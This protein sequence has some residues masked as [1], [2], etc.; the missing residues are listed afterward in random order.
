MTLLACLGRDT[1]LAARCPLDRS[2]ARVQPLSDSLAEWSKALASGASPQGRGFK[3]HSCHLRES[4]I[5]PA[6]RAQPEERARAVDYLTVWPS[7]LRRWLKAPVRKGVGSNP[8]AVTSSIDADHGL[9]VFFSPS[10]TPKHN[11]HCS[12]KTKVDTLGIEPRASRM[13][14][15]CDT[16][17]PCAHSKAVPRQT[18]DRL[19]LFGPRATCSGIIFP[20]PGL[21]PGSLG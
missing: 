2:S 15:G 12:A 14:S 18:F 9:P 1:A 3:P 20:P 6:P 21:E 7:G 16:A 8:T 5:A 13:L 17:T 11:A 19:S 10:T 4:R